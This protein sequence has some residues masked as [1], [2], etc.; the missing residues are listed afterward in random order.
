MTDFPLSA[1]PLRGVVFDLD[2]LMFDTEVL[3][4][5]VGS[6]VLAR[7]GCEFTDE[8][9]NQMM[10]R[11]SAKALQ[12]MIDYH[13]LDTTVPELASESMEVMRKLLETRLTPMPGLIPLLDALEAADL[14]MAIATSSTRDFLD[15]VLE[16]S[17]LTD[18]FR[19]TLSGDDIEHGKPAPD[20]YLLAAQ[21]LGFP[22]QEVLVLEDSQLGCQ[23]AVAAGNYAVAVPS[24][25]SHTHQFP[26]AKFIA[27]SL[28]DSR[29]YR[30]LNIA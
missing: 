19:F 30:A 15:H 23:A 4:Q 12:I 6:T 5:E 10:G 13:E 9:L 26:G 3:Y 7:R 1:T 8:L 22:P 11:Q 18:R 2:G 28:L 24:G 25:H 21:K 29:I 27:D 16:L 14:P 20:V 17:D